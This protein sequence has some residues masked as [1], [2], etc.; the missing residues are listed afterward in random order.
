MIW[1]VI[2]MNIHLLDEMDD[3]TKLG[4]QIRYNLSYCNFSFELW[5]ILH[6]KYLVSPLS[7]RS[8]YL[9]YINQVFDERFQSLKEYKQKNNF[10]RILTKIQLEDV[11]TAINHAEKIMLENKKRYRIKQYK[12]FKYYDE[13]PSLNIWEIVNEIISQCGLNNVR[14]LR[15]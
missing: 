12:G 15:R 9:S 13:N 7:D 6:K 10:T 1:K 14:A 8:Q 4:R 11:I 3:A 2:Q 5:M